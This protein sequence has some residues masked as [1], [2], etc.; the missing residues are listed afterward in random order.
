MQ[1]IQDGVVKEE[2]GRDGLVGIFWERNLK[3]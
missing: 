1:K 2:T 3:T